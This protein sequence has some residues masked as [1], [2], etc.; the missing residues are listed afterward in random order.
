MAQNLWFNNNYHLTPFCETLK[1]QQIKLCFREMAWSLINQASIFLSNLKIL[2]ILAA[3]WVNFWFRFLFW[4][5]LRSVF[6]F[7][8]GLNII[9]LVSVRFRFRLIYRFRSITTSEQLFCTY[10]LGLYMFG[11][12]KLAHKLLVKCWW[13]W[14]LRKER[15]KKEFNLQLKNPKTS[16]DF[17][18]Q[19]DLTVLWQ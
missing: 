5:R 6:G 8:F 7:G 3:V 19:R 2:Y 14:P 16:N 1:H 13:N 4:F 10:I 12:R 17:G 9:N 18:S 15:V 11:A